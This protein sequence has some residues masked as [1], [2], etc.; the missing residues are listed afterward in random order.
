MI[1]EFKQKLEKIK[2]E[3]KKAAMAGNRDPQSV[4]L[5][6]VSKTKPAHSVKQAIA[7]GVTTLG[8]NYIQEASKKIQDLS[9]YPAS[10]H[11]IG[12]LQRNKAK[13]AVRLFDL[14]HSVDSLKLARE[15]NKQAKKNNKI[16][17]ILVQ[18]NIGDQLSKSGV[19]PQKCLNLIQEISLLQ[20]L[21]VRGFMTM[22][23]FFDN[24]EKARPFF[25]ELR[26][27]RDQIKKHNVKNISMNQLSM[28]MTGDFQV[29]VQEGATLVRIGTALFGK[30]ETQ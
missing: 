28:G 25:S 26:N 30:R 2:S 1:Q 8:E 10:W 12:H 19:H 22:P 20:N 13:D 4:R 11:F 16:Q 3:I 9:S 17:N 27:L 15:L 7:A 24:P 14:I 29:A 5:V 18:V 21:S 6:G 23:P